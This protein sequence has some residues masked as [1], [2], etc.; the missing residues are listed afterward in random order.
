MASENN[1]CLKRSSKPRRSCDS[2]S[3]LVVDDDTTCLAVVAALLKKFKYSVVTAKHPNDALCALRIKGG[4]FDLV[5]S[6]VNMPD[7]NGFQLREAITHEFNLPVI[8]MSVD[9]KEVVLSKANKSGAALFISKPVSPNDLKD[10]WQFAA[11]K[12][13][14]NSNENSKRR[15]Q[16]KERFECGDA[17]TKKPKVI[18]TNALHYRFLEAIRSIGLE[19]AVPKKILQVMDVPGLTRENVASHLQKYRMFLKRVSDASYKLEAGEDDETMIRTTSYVSNYS[20]NRLTKPQ[21]RFESFPVSYQTHPTSHISLG[22]N[23]INK[24][25]EI[26]CALPSTTHLVHHQSGNSVNFDIDELLNNTDQT[27][28]A[29]HLNEPLL[30][31]PLPTSNL[32]LVQDQQFNGGIVD[33]SPF[34]SVYDLPASHVQQ[35]FNLNPT[36]LHSSIPSYQLIN[37]QNQQQVEGTIDSV[38]FGTTSS[39]FHKAIESTNQACYSCDYNGAALESLLAFGLFGEDQIQTLEGI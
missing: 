34:C 39:Q 29:E 16:N 30:L 35:P 21:F 33:D 22:S 20:L 38:V 19:R 1:I 18:W 6:D 31:P 23:S 11:M 32:S 28:F 9:S 7:M 15:P 2:I 13:K 14:V 5:V 25:S 10:L 12:K 4:S 17:N 27:C 26:A 37:F 3:I 8:L 24:N 36:H